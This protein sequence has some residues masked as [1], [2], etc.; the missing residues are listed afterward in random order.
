[1]SKRLQVYYY[2]VFGALGGLLGWWI[3]GSF[4]TQVWNIWV[5]AIFVGA[6]LGVCMGGLIAATEGAMVKKVLSRALRDGVLGGFAGAV[7]G[8]IGLLIAQIV[9]SFLHGGFIAR[10]FVWA[11]LGLLIGVSDLLVHRRLQRALYAGFGGFVGGLIGGFVYEG[12]TQLFLSQSGTA[13]IAIGGIGLVIVGACIGGLIPLARQV[14]SQGELRVLLG[15][16]AGL[17]REVSDNAT[18]GR[19]DGND[20]YLPDTGVSWRHAMVR[21]GGDGFELY[22]LPE[23]DSEALVGKN[24]IGPGNTCGL[25]N[26]DYIRIGEAMMQF[27]GR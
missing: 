6:G 19:Y 22:V 8:F 7:A 15:E 16:Q 2:A 24:A 10:A 14:L 3:V 1:M 11:V 21:R 4:P 17:V 5:A 27:V 12:L 18:I 26:G 20:L 13:Q 25:Q 9:W 23:A